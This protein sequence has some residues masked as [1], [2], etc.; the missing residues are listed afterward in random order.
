MF[1]LYIRNSILDTGPIINLNEGPAKNRLNLYWHLDETER[2]SYAPGG[3]H[4]G[5]L[6]RLKY[7]FK[8]YWLTYNGSEWCLWDNTHLIS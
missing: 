6:I 5:G 8:N 4:N 7:K 3:L 1:W 2:L